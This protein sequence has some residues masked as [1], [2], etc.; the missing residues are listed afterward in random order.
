MDMGRFVASQL[1]T[2][3]DGSAEL[4]PEAARQLMLEQ[5]FTPAA[6]MPG[7][8]YGYFESDANGHRSLHHTG[9]GG[10]HSLL[11]LVPDAKL[12]FFLV[13]TAPRQGDTSTPREQIAQDLIDHYL[14][15]REPFAQPEPPPDFA[16]GADRYVGTYRVE[17]YDHA[18]IEKLA[19][20]GQEITITNP[21]DGTLGAELGDGA[22]I[23]LVESGPN[24]FRDPDGAYVAFRADTTGRITAP[25]F[26]G[27]AVDDPGSAERIGWFETANANLIFILLGASLVLV[28]VVAEVA[29]RLS[30]R[31]T[32][33]PAATIA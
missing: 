6:T 28:R 8:A 1:G 23:R 20:L 31:R 15:C 26:S 5:H 11:Y 18:T 27:A 9:D 30:G 13:Y 19:A 3:F 17:P 21:G 33:R 14:G 4:M 22:P 12:G 16:S 25:S 32:A 7:S 29:V 10:D 2:P 24:L